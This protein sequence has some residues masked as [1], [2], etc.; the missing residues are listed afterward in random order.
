MEATPV[1]IIVATALLARQRPVKARMSRL[2]Q[3]SMV[4]SGHLAVA[5]QPRAERVLLRRQ[6][7]SLLQVRLQMRSA[8]TRLQR[9]DPVATCAAM[10]RL[11]A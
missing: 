7:G 8:Q 3:I 10:E 1:S 11:T 2:L 9:R 6:E 5:A 4:I